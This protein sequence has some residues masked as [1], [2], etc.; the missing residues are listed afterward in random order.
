LEKVLLLEE[1]KPQISRTHVTL[2]ENILL[3]P[4]EGKGCVFSFILYFLVY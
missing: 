1:V 2:V 3:A 4:K